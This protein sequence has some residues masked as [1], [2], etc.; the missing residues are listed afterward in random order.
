MLGKYSM[1]PTLVTRSIGDWDAS[2]ACIPQ[3]EL[4]RFE[5]AAGARA[6]IAIA[7]DGLWDFASVARAAEMIHGMRSAKASADKLLRHAVLKSNQKFN[8]LKDDTTVVVVDLD[9]RDAAARAADKP[10][11]SSACCNVQ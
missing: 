11:S 5:I 10:P 6:R 7:S 2:R 4:L 9:C 8:Q 3:P 1:T